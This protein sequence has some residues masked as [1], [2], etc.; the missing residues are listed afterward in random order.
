M[1]E[2]L[3]YTDHHFAQYSPNGEDD[4]EPWCVCRLDLLGDAFNVATKDQ[5][6]ELMRKMDAYRNRVA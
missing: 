1:Q 5:A 2:P 4:A 6:I 3:I